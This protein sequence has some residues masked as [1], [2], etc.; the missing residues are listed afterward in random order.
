MDTDTE[1]ELIEFLKSTLEKGNVVHRDTPLGV[2]FI[3]ALERLSWR[4]QR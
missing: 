2:A 3:D 1:L 4:R